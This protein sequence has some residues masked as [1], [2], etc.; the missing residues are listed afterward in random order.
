MVHSTPASRK[1]L[2]D[3]AYRILKEKLVN[4]EFPPGSM[5]NEAQL[6]AELG[7]SR[8]PIREAIS[9][10]ETEGYLQIVPKK[11][12]LVTDILLSD[13]LQI[14][15]ARMEI[16]PITLKMA[17]PNLPT[18]ELIKWRDK[19]LNKPPDF[20]NGFRTDTAMHMFI[21]EHCN[22]SYIIEMMKK[23]FDKNMR[24]IISSKQNR[25]H[26]EEAYK[27]HIE[28]LNALIDKDYEYGA[29]L[30]QKH[31]N[32]CRRAALDYFYNL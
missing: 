11:G 24:I 10:L 29:S 12:I 13:V 2:K 4:C 7:F 32:N 16:E 23:I 20:E 14:F 21:I 1:T 28:I 15:Q 6:S 19:F 3:Q 31:V 17:G 18:E 25:V 8:T 27:E 5:L 26:I 9:V 30:M 22:N